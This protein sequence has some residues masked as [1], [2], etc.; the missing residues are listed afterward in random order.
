[1]GLVKM[2]GL[3]DSVLK[4]FPPLMTINKDQFPK[5]LESLGFSANRTGGHMARSMMLDEMSQLQSGLP[6]TAS[7]AEFQ[8]AIETDN[9]LGKP[10]LSSRQKSFRHLLELYGL[11]NEQA[12]F[13]VLRKVGELDP[14]SFPLMAAVCV[15]CRDAQLRSSFELILQKNPGDI[16]PRTEMEQHLETCFPD[17]FSEAMK[18]SLAQNVNTSWTACGH[19]VG[20]TKKIRALPQP[21][22]GAVCYAMFAGWLSG[23][24][25]EFLIDSIFTKLVAADPGSVLAH[26]RSGSAMGLLRFRSGGGVTEID[27][28][29]L[30]TPNELSLIHGAY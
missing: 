27:F 5:H 26:L 24:R 15:F 23:L 6:I 29:Q 3:F 17:R 8:A 12:L 10:T 14:S 19:L 1:M 11:D 2:G 22:V 4:H 20:R 21:G 18:K 28:S 25:G 30:L 9:F 16:I 13:R 7:K